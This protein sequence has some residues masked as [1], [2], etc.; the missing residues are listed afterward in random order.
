VNG[1]LEERLA[2]LEA[3][4]AIHALK[5][6]YARLADEKYTSAHERVPEPAWSETAGAQA[7]CFTANASWIG[8]AQFGGTIQGRT[9][10]GDWFTRSPWCFAM[11]YYV[12]PQLTLTAP[13]AAEGRWRL[14][15]V[16][17][18]FDGT[19][20]VLLAAT[21]W[22]TYRCVDGTWLIASMRFEEIQQLALTSVPAVLQCT[23]PRA[24]A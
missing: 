8:G 24:T 17:L 20:P 2:R 5:A 14:W 21:T 7:A 3:L 15:Q 10:L 4:E 11:H 16:G 23:L 19:S 13:D 18:P 22:E 1:T 9:A 12:S 6:R